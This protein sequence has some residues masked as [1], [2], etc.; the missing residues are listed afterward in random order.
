M[1]ENIELFING[2]WCNASDGAT[3]PVTCPASEDVIGS[4]AVAADDDIN[5]ALSAAKDG[6]DVWRKTGTWDRAA[7]IRKVADLIRERQSEIARLMSLETGKPLAESMGETGAA[8]DQFE[9]YSEETKRIYG[10]II[11]ARTSDS[12]M[13]VI[14]QPV[15]VVAAF[16]AWNFPALLPARKIAAALGAGCAIIIKPA[17]E[18]PASCAALIQACHDAGIPPG[19]V[20]MLTGNSGQIAEKL[21]RSPIVRKVSVTGSVPV[22]KQ[23]LSLAAEGVKK[24]SMELGGHGPVLVFDDFD[25]EKAAEICAPT[26][27]R[28]CGQVCISPTR[29]YVHENSYE[30]FASRFAEIANSLKIGRGLDDGVQIGP[31]AN[32]RG[33]ETIQKMTQ[34]A[35]DR[36][37]E[38]LAG[39]KRP[40]GFNKGYFVEP[41]VL[42]RVPDDA[43]VMTEEPFGPIAPI[44]TF[45]DYDEVIARANSLP[46]GLA[47]YVFSNN[48]TTATRA[49]EDLELGMVG[50]NEMLLATAEAPFGGVKESGMGRE[51]G[52]LGMHDYLDPK[53]VKMKLAG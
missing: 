50:V 49:Y 42:G 41:T 3:K 43:L 15:G 33:L 8:A 44:T 27:F 20:N 5:R 39:G 17:G 32:K 19:V 48:L 38:L 28:N 45:T 29:F 11:E 23:I 46:F 4:I 24:V 31:M 36:G 16:S 47:G 12:R 51:G 13:A 40:A 26:K 7:K 37:A 52:S 30:K 1:Y 34:D 22:G 6:F 14:Y 53:Y 18:T 2:D 9:W 21:I 25:A 10:Q 35:L